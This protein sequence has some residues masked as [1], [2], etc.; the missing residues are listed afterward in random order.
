MKLENENIF[1]VVTNDNDNVVLTKLHSK[2]PTMSP[3]SAANLA[4]WLLVQSGIDSDAFA[5]LVEEVKVTPR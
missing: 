2:Y 3:E 1:G 5:Q 4:A